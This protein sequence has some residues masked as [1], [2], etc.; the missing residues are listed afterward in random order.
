[1]VQCVRVLG[2]L[3][4]ISVFHRWM[5]CRFRSGAAMRMRVH[6]LAGFLFGNI[7]GIQPWWVIRCISVVIFRN[8]SCPIKKLNYLFLVIVPIT[9]VTP[10]CSPCLDKYAHH[11]SSAEYIPNIHK[12]QTEGC[13]FYCMSS[14]S[15]NTIMRID[16]S[17]AC[18]IELP[19]SICTVPMGSEPEAEA[20]NVP[21]I[22]ILD[23]RANVVSATSCVMVF[24]CVDCKLEESLVASIKDFN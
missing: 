1:M 10:R 7:R 12:P 8:C 21:I 19:K 3:Q 16:I 17:K 18:Q 15:A 4:A 22:Y 11:F 24:P 6:L 23:V 13:L 9:I 20:D 14:S 2:Y 5:C